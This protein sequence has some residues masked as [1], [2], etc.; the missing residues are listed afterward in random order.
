MYEICLGRPLPENGQEWQDMRAGTLLPMPN[1]AFDLQMIIREMMSPDRH[2]RPSAEDLLKKR[3]LLSDEQR[4]LITERNRAE[5][6]NMALD[7]Q[8]VSLYCTRLSPPHFH[9]QF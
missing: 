7:A 4:M 5:A 1:T 8:M 9:P 6:A 3:Q 2:G